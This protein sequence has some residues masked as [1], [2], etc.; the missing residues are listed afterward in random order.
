MFI[1]SLEKEEDDSYW[2]ELSAPEFS[3]A[4]Y[5]GVFLR[6]TSGEDSDNT[7]NANLPESCEN[8]AAK[9]TEL[10][11]EIPSKEGNEPWWNA[12]ADGSC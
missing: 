2:P 7:D 6:K 4:G 8:P 11:E 9:D 1:D 5:Y 10:T 12:C 3:T